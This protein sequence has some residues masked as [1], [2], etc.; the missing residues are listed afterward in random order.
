MAISAKARAAANAF[1]NEGGLSNF[2]KPFKFTQQNIFAYSNNNKEQVPPGAKFIVLMDQLR[3]GLV[4]LRTGE[5]P[6][7]RIG[8]V[9][10]GYQPPSRES[11]GDN[12]QMDWETGRDGKP[13]DP[14]KSH[15]YL[16][17]RHVE[18]GEAAYFD[19][20][21][22]GGEQAVR[23]LMAEYLEKVGESDDKPVITLGSSSYD[24]DR[25]GKTI[26][27]PAFT[28]VGWHGTDASQTPPPESEPT[29][30]TTDAP[31]PV[32]KSPKAKAT[33]ANADMDDDIPF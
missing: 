25:A 22:Q 23:D 7:Y 13:M 32:K 31:Q 20:D 2:G 14:W 9:F 3:R 27:N 19:T 18:T 16:P 4:R 26:Y 5:R 33:K 6:Q 15:Y 30:S 17:L 1:I 11:L 24:S 8:L 10:D 29:S 12:D 21:S 28:I